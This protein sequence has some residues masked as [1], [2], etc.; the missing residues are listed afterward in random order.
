[1]GNALIIGV[2][3]LLAETYTLGDAAG[4]DPD[5]FQEFVDL[6]FPTPSYQAYGRKIGHEN[7]SSAGGF[8][9]AGGLKGELGRQGG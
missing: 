4:I 2:I 3:E 1:M 9:L 8:R 7:Y 5:V 6:F